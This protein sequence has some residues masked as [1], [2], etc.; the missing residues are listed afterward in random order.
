LV[1]RSY[2]HCGNVKYPWFPGIPYAVSGNWYQ[3]A[4]GAGE[5]ERYYLCLALSWSWRETKR[6]KGG[7]SGHRKSISPINFQKFLELTSQKSI[8]IKMSGV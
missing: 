4:D 2:E 3:L 1:R 5:S 6:G 8:I 7:V